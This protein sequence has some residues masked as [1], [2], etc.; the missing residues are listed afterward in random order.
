MTI[1]H[2]IGNVL[3]GD[4]LEDIPRGSTIQIE[5]DGKHYRWSPIDRSSTLR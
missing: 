5:R 1:L 4:A 3:N 2:Q